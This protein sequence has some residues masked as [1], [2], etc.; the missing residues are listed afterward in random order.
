MA[1]Q[2]QRLRS[3]LSAMTTEQ[4]HAW[5]GHLRQEI[6]AL[7]K[8]RPRPIAKLYGRRGPTP[9]QAARYQEETRT[10]NRAWRGVRAEYKIAVDVS[11]GRH[12]TRRPG[13]P[14]DQGA[15]SVT[16]GQAA[17]EIEHEIAAIALR[18]VLLP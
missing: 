6:V 9:E 7:Q 10:W 12:Y 16:A 8:E 11:N 17:R 15:P 1:N 18:E 3:Q 2:Q 14:A 5:M 13:Q 4:L